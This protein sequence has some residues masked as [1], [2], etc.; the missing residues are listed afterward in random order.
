[1]ILADAR[2]RMLFEIRPD[3]FPE[4]FLTRTEIL[5]WARFYTDRAAR[6]NSDKVDKAKK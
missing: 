6:A 1:M 5:L 2:G 3:F 4:G